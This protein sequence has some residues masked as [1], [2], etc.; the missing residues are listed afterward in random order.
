MVYRNSVFPFIYVMGAKN[1]NNFS[2]IKLY[3]KF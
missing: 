2:E 1:L 3:E